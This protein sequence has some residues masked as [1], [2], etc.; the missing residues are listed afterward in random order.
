MIPRIVPFDKKYDL[1]GFDCGVPILNKYLKTQASQDIRNYYNIA[2]VALADSADRIVGFYTLSNAGISLNQIPR[3]AQKKL[4]KYTDIPAI[5]LG[6]LAV[7]RS[8]QGTGV[9][10]A[11]LADAV[12][13]SLKSTAWAVMVVDAKDAQASAFY[14]KHGF[15]TVDDDELTL[16]LLRTA[17]LKFISS[18]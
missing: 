13:Q 3:D 11:L 16:I 2:F 12:L 8:V 18:A 15:I 17:L 10:K 4:P 7:D 1:S 5:R 6:R 14:Q 9:G